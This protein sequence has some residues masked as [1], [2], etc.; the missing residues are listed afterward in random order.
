[1]H[2]LKA[3]RPPS[4]PQRVVGKIII[5]PERRQRAEADGV[6]EEDLGARVDPNLSKFKNT[7]SDFVCVGG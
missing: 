6:A 4:S 2:H 1:M 7:R 3:R 5:A